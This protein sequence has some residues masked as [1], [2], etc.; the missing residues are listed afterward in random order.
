MDYKKAINQIVSERSAA[1][2]DARIL[3]LDLLREDPQLYETEK[4]IRKLHMLPLNDRTDDYQS[5]LASL[6]SKKKALLD[7][8]GITDQ[9]LDPPP[10][11]SKCGDTGIIGDKP[12]SCVIKRC[13]T[14]SSTEYVDFDSCDLSVFPDY[15]RQRIENVYKTAKGFCD[16]FPATKKLNVIFMGKCGSG[17]TFAASCMAKAV[18]DKGYSVV[19]LSSFAFVNRMLKY[20]VADYSEKL[21]YLEPIIDCDLL[22]I[23]DLGSENIIKNVTAE[24]LFHVINERMSAKKHTVIT[25]NLD[26]P[27]I[28]ERYGERTYSRLF[29]SLSYG[30][31]LSDT[32]LR[33]H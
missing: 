9:M 15:E 1:L 23:D 11:C 20:H 21:Q 31:A 28:R 30:A 3:F 8:K 12:C 32:D 14:D 7:K 6:E 18:S 29:G 24:Y 5:E 22:V 27:M 33:A 25:T 19:M 2:A 13:V 10:K 4:A 26:A 16:K 17:K